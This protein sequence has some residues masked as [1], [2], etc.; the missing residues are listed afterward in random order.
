[1]DVELQNEVKTLIHIITENRNRQASGPVHTLP[2]ILLHEYSPNGVGG[3]G[4][5]K[6]DAG[7]V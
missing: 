5:S 4:V 3:G 1:M 6:G 2:S 7:S